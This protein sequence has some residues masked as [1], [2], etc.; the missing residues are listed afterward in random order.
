MDKPTLFKKLSTI[1]QHIEEFK[2]NVE[3]LPTGFPL[4]D[5][6]LDGGFFKKEL[7]V[8]GAKTGGGK[9]LFGGQIF[10]SVATSGFNSAYFSLE[11]S[12]EM[13]VSR[14]I[15][16]EANLSPARVMYKLLSEE[17]QQKRDEAKA[18]LSVYEEFMYFYD[19]LYRYDEIEKEILENKYDFVVVD[20]IQNVMVRGDEYERMSQIALH[21]QQLAKK[22]NCCILVLSQLSNDMVR[23]KKNTGLVEYKGSGSIATVCDLGFFVEDT[24]EPGRMALRLRKNRRGVSGEVFNF[25]VQHPGGKIISL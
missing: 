3:I 2:K 20:F 1:D 5:S 13:I 8:L 15:G 16:A 14:L 7:V 4:L 19:D 21:F 10:Q 24:D 22:T 17:E 23:S 25:M 6:F 12:N 11:I 9:S 18:E